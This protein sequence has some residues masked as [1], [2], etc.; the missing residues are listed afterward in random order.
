MKKLLND[1]KIEARCSYCANGKL[2]PTGDSVLCKKLGI[3]DPEFS[4]N[5]FKYDVLKRQPR[6]PREIE[7]FEAEDFSLSIDE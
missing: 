7:H 3:V 4:C 6:R 5:K 1:K 2:A